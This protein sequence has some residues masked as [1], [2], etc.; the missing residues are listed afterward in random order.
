[1][2]QS[3][4]LRVVFGVKVEKSDNPWYTDDEDEGY[5][6]WWRKETGFVPTFYPYDGRGEYAEGV[7]KDDPRIAAYYNELREW[8]KEH[9]IPFGIE[10]DGGY[11]SDYIFVCAP[12]N[13]I[14][15]DAASLS[16]II[17]N[18][19]LEPEVEERF[20]EFLRKYYDGLEPKWWVVPFYG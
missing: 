4:S 17:G 11:E 14:Y 12:N 7:T 6:D 18:S 5:E 3:V 10:Y 8:E 19:G 16:E 13:K 2:G 9:P 15:W 1:M 20:R